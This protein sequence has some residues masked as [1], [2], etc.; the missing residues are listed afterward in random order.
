MRRATLA[1]MSLVLHVEPRWISP[2][3]FACFVTLTEKGLAFEA[4]ELD[5]ARAETRDADYLAATITGR[6]PSLVHDGFG[7]AESS[8][9]VEYL[10]EAFP[11]VPVLPRDLRDRARARQLMSW[12]R[13]DDT[14]PIRAERPSASIFHAPATSPLSAEAKSAAEKLCAVATRLLDGGRGTIF[15]RWSIVDAELAFMLQRLLSSGDP[16]PGPIARWAGAQWERPSVQAFVRR[17]RPLR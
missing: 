3:V 11:E 2:Y 1:R 14:A 17:D 13:S 15:E 16:V 6:V 9:I 12:L 10:E 4:R 8:A 7:L 5:A